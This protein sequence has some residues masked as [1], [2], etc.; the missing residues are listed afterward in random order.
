MPQ[1]RNP[2]CRDRVYKNAE[3]RRPLE[4]STNSP[5]TRAARAV[6]SA[7]ASKI[8]LAASAEIVAAETA[9]SCRFS[10]RRL[11]VTTMTSSIELSGCSAPVA[12]MSELSTLCCVWA[13]T[14]CAKAIASVLADRERRIKERS[15]IG[16]IILLTRHAK[17]RERGA[18]GRKC[19][20]TQTPVMRTSQ[21]C[22]SESPQRR[23]FPP[24]LQ[25]SNI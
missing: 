12:S 25:C 4:L 21:N 24:M 18:G 17:I 15:I 19:K 22:S 20:L 3:Q 8:V 7:P 16:E 13:I 11:A 23:G 9:T 2:Y 14:G 6:I 10:S 1:G 5:G